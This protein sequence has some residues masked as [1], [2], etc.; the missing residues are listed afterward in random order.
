MKKW[1]LAGFLFLAAAL[2]GGC[3]GKSDKPISKTTTLFDTVVT[4]KIYDEDAGDTLNAAINKCQEYDNRLSRTKEGSEIY[5][6]NNAGGQAVQLSPDTVNLINKGLEYC[7]LSEGLFDITTAPLSDLWDFKNNPGTVPDEYAISEALSHVNYHTVQVNDNVVQLLDPQAGIDLG[8]IAKG[9]IADQI[10]AFL[11]DEGVRHAI[12]DLGGN[13]LTIGGKPDGTSFNIGIQ[14]PFA[15]L[16]VP[17]TSVKLKDRSIVSSG[18]YQRYFKV[19]DKIYHHILNTST[20]YPYDND[21]LGVTVVCASS[22]EADA[23]STT[24]FAMGLNRGMEFINN[25]PDVE[26]V[27]ITSDYKMHYSSGFKR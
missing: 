5:Q 17:I 13:V 6:L 19:D 26:A 23:L 16:G 3:S 14:K 8:G 7:D 20:G 4:I 18:V 9:Y 25:R 15:E 1:K 21:L 10:K 22:T 2:L 11:K 12:I 27:F 24:C